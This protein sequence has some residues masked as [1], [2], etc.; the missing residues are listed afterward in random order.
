L[1]AESAPGISERRVESS[2]G[3]L[4]AVHDFGAREPGP[5]SEPVL[6]VHA[7]GFHGYVWQPL[8][9]HLHGRRALAPDLRGHGDSSSPSDGDYAWDGF[10]DDV[11]AVVDQL[12]L[13]GVDA[14]GHSKGG[15][16]LLLAEQ[17]EP[18]TFRRLYLYEPVV[19]PPAVSAG[20]SGANPL[21]E[22]ARRRRAIFPSRDVAYE[23]F[24]G[25]PPFDVL[26]PVALHAYVDHG[27][28]DQPDG[29]VR[30]KCAP[31]DEAEVYTMG[32]RHGAFEHLGSVTC[33]VTIARG[34]VTDFGPAAFAGQ[35]AAALPDGR[36]DVFDDLGHFG[37]LQRP[38][39]VAA[40]IQNRWSA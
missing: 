16:A 32:S 4:L 9:A 29:T 6:L 26:D 38:D 14:V 3:V 11:L 27:F 24:A 30:L 35:I 7:T 21:A 34:A 39:E 19:I 8:A 20:A 31:D 28:E 1:S 18:G 23:N 33:P 13:G 22:G 25:K 40:A 17:R 10:A 36:L 12:G 15:A 2:D 5:S 37:P